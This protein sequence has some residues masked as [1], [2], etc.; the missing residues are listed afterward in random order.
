M[1]DYRTMDDA[2]EWAEVGERVRRARLAANLTQ[3]ELAERMQ[4][5]RTMI[6]KIEAGTRRIDAV[7]LARLSRMLDVS[8]GFIL[9]PAPAVLSRRTVALTPDTDTEAGRESS[10]LDIALEEWL[11]NLRQIA[12]YGV[13]QARPLVRYAAPVESA[14]QA[15]EAARWVRAELGYGTGPIASLL[16][17]C[18][19]AGQFVLVTEIKG[20]GASVVDGD[21]A[22]AVVSLTGDPGRR[23]ATAAHELGHLVLGDEY[24]SD[25]GVHASRA[26]REALIDAFAAELLVPVSAFAGD[27]A[28]E[29][30][31]LLE[32]AASYRASWS[33]TLRQAELATRTAL[34]RSLYHSS[35]TRAEFIDAVGWAPQPDLESLR[36]PPSYAHAVMQAWRDSWIVRGRAVELMH[37]QIKDSDL[38][39]D[40]F[41][42]AEYIP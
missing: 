10:R 7:E 20:D 42:D 19:R 17:L 14:P 5:D 38:P 34:P 6:A 24:S 35:P 23:R 8:M 13:L 12:S 21:L 31:K 32:V 16:E 30:D 3:S 28:V 36:V 25:L 26:E 22:A 39:V 27:E 15:R 4:L 33:L 37:G 1:C 2:E 41:D 29:R 40:A 18:E 9:E 11:R